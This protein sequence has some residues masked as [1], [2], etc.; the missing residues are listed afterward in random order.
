MTLPNDVVRSMF[1]HHLW[2][3]ETLIDHL[4][5][6]PS[7]RLDEAIPGTY[8]S[9]VATLTHLVDAD[10]RYLVRFED[11]SPP[12]AEDRAGVPLATLREEVA[13]RR[14]QWDRVLDRLERGELTAAVRAKPHYPDTDDAEGL[15]LLQAVQHGNDHRTQICSTLGALGEQVPELD[16][17]EYW[18]RGRA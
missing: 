8:G 3:T 9:M 14:G 10:G 18:A 12:P 6:L 15:L 17:W 4:A 5:G 2:A 7:E 11:P 1:A 16:G 13:G